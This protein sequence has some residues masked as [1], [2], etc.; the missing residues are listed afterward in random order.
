MFRRTVCVP[1]S[2]RGRSCTIPLLRLPPCYAGNRVRSGPAI[3][4]PP[5]P[6]SFGDRLRTIYSK[7]PCQQSILVPPRPAVYDP[8][9][10]VR[11]YSVAADTPPAPGA[12]CRNS[13]AAGR[14]ALS[15]RGR[16]CTIPPAADC[17]YSVAAG[18][19]PSFPAA[20]RVQSTCRDWPFVPRP[21]AFCGRSRAISSRIPSRGRSF[22]FCRGRPPA[23]RG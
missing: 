4:T 20:G 8:H 9:A 21:A 7:I 3:L 18:C 1:S 23:R 16:L 19:V 15:P 6:S 2:P 22:A 11:P 14:P 13:P 12:A 5:R 10:V 17:P